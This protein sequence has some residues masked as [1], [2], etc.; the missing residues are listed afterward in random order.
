MVPKCN[1][2]TYGYRA[3]SHT[4]PTLWNALLDDIWQVDLLDNI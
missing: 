4:A 1:L 3:F 2:K